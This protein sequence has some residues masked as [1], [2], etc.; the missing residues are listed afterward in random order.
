MN[1]QTADGGGASLIDFLVSEFREPIRDPLWG[2]ILLSPAFEAVLST[3]DF[4]RLARIRQLGPAYLVY[5]GA[6]HSRLAHSLGVFHLARRLVLALALRGELEFTNREGLA[7]FLAAALAHDLG[8]F[9]YAHS[10]KELSLEAHE[11][12]TARLLLEEPLKS[13]VGATGAD[14]ELAAA[15][16]DD[17]FP[18]GGDR[19]VGFFRSLLSG[20]LDPD[21]L[22][23]LNRDAYFC[24]VPY[25]KQDTEFILERL[26]IMPSG[27]LGVEERG[28]MSV[29][30][31]LFSK[32]LMYRSV[33]WH[34]TVRSATA[35][36]KKAVFLG[37]RAGKLRPEEL[38]R[39]DD[40]SFLSLLRSRP[41]PAFGLAAEILEGRIW[42]LA[43][44]LPYDDAD[45]RHRRLLDLEARLALEQ[46]LEERAASHGLPLPSP[47]GLLI[48]IPETI[49]FESDLPILDESG[50]ER[51]F[52]ES[53]TVFSPAVVERF[54]TRLRK[55]R[56]YLA[57]PA[58][59]IA[60]Y[61]R[62]ELA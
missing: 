37:L 57:L 14:P 1:T 47:F 36:V 9:P 56:L 59:T 13:L 55:I 3:P 53:S 50:N 45:P 26:R 18:G 12:L 8:H 40:A 58:P 29:E 21:K 49:S 39:L 62:E 35:L 38:Y 15:I 28:L 30:G 11:T 17:R 4:A 2:N 34:K 19:E 22:D 25:G 42:P 33:Y 7:S 61:L 48:D 51:A 46:S 16:V 31:V 20:V 44:E 41:H 10:L 43:L 5:P 27:R 52:S 32:Y 54:S 23:Y 60:E 6:S 24:G